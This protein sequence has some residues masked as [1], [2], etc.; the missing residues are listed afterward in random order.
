MCE[1]IKAKSLR[2]FEPRG[3][4]LEGLG[5]EKEIT[6]FLNLAIIILQE[7]ILSNL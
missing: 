2:F 1:Y 6:P 5:K 3:S 7:N 4:L